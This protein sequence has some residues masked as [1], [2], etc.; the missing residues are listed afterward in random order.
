MPRWSERKSTEARDRLEEQL[1]C[2]E[3]MEAVGALAGGAA[4]DLNKILGGIVSYSE[5]IPA[6]SSGEEPL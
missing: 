3:K 4:H 6:G 1:R 5:L 2:S